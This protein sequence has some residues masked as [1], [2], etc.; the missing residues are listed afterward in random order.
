MRDTEKPS[1]SLWPL[2]KHGW[3]HTSLTLLVF[4][5][6][7]PQISL[8]PLWRSFSHSLHYPL[9]SFYIVRVLSCPCLLGICTLGS[10]ASQTSTQ[11]PLTLTTS[12]PWLL[13]LQGYKCSNYQLLIS[14]STWASDKPLS[15]RLIEALSPFCVAL[16]SSWQPWSIPS[17]VPAFK[18]SSFLSPQRPPHQQTL[19][20]TASVIH[21]F[22]CSILT[23]F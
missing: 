8:L 3:G 22:H 14:K 16:L 7:V 9:C 18:P 6:L 11:R 10:S 20:K 21:L 1:E 13:P 15:S 2:V 4:E 5:V 12:E 23:R 17:K 19:S